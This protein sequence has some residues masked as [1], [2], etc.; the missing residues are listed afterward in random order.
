MSVADKGAAGQAGEGGSRVES[1]MTRITYEIVQH[2]GGWAYKLGDVFSETFAS[3]DDALDAA[4]R[5]AA[6]QQRAGDDEPIAYEDEKGRWHEEM[7][8]GDDRP[9]VEVKD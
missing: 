1:S 5:V 6:E 9:D 7:S 4:N 8:S 2:A 3:H